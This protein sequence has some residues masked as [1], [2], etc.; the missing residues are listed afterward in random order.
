MSALDGVVSAVPIKR[1]S[2]EN[3]PPIASGD[4]DKLKLYVIPP[5]D[6]GGIIS[7]LLLRLRFPLPLSPAPF[8]PALTL[9]AIALGN[10]G[11][12]VGLL[13]YVGDSGG[14]DGGTLGEECAR[15]SAPDV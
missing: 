7:L 5:V 11:L 6:G 13:E 3:C 14:G 2:N 10:T 15:T 12:G 9:I 8:E 1:D 4:D